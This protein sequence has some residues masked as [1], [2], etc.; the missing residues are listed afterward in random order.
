MKLSSTL[1]ITLIGGPTALIELDGFRLLTDPT[2]DAP[3]AYQLP[4]VKLEKLAGPA[5]TVDKI[6][7]IRRGAA[8]SRSA[9]GQSRS[10]RK[11]FSG[12][13]RARPTPTAQS[14]LKTIDAIQPVIN[15]IA[16]VTRP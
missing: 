9:F 11:G 16:A 5:L 10:F 3:G 14:F 4:H 1:S 15:A 8:E 7:E 13:G 12:Q 2:F 6:G